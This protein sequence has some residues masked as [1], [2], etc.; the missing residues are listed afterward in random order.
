[1]LF[2]NVYI[3]VNR[4]KGFKYFPFKSYSQLYVT[5]STLYLENV[6]FNNDTL[7]LLFS[8][9]L[10]ATNYRLIVDEITNAGLIS[11]DNKQLHIP[12]LKNIH[13]YQLIPADTNQLEITLQID[14]SQN[15][16]GNFTNEF[17]Y[18]NLPGPQ[19]KVS[20]YNLWTRGISSLNSNEVE[21]GN[22]LLAENTSAFSALTDSARLVE[23]CRLI[24]KLRPNKNGIK[25]STVSMQPAYDQLKYAMQ[26]KINLDCGN[27]SVMIHYLCNLLGL[28]S[29]VITFSGPAGNWQYGVHYY[30]EVNL[31]EKQ[32]WVLCDGVSN[33]YMP[34]DT[35][36]FYNAADVYKMAHVNSFNNKSAY[37]FEGNSLKEVRYDSLSY[38][39]SYYNRNNAN[40]CYLHPGTGVQDGKLNYVKDFYSFDR[41]FDFY[42]D[43]NQ[44]DWMKICIKLAA[45]YL[46]LIVAL[47]YFV[48]EINRNRK[49]DKN[50][51]HR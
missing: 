8:L 27:Y 41:N 30:N 20:D 10:P 14:H 46:M 24:S 33:A 28:P 44:N 32:Q 13:S 5:D 21:N 42:S 7:A 19:I 40:L 38:W 2:I 15:T 9:K 36:R 49:I 3:L 29:R 48:W 16:D 25:A 45:F 22:E 1:M 17:I 4:N 11:S 26:N 43:I 35:I 12:L 31:R 37:T 51:V 50:I 47:T 18:C 39:H 6:Q 23:V 34:H